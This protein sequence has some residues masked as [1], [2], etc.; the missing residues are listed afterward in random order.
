MKKLRDTVQVTYNEN[1]WRM[2]AAVRNICDIFDEASNLL[3]ANDVTSSLVVQGNITDI[4][5]VYR[6]LERFETMG[7][8]HKIG[9]KFIKCKDPT[10]QHQQH[11]FLICDR[12]DKAEEIFL[13]YKESIASQ[14]KNE[15]GFTLKDVDMTFHGRCRDCQG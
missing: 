1:G 10:N 7:V 13:N 11:H 15:K 14:L 9:K 8:I 4:T 5:T 3:S 12:C 6:I 2:T